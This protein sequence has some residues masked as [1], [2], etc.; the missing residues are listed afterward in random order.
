[1]TLVGAGGPQNGFPMP[2]ELFRVYAPIGEALKE[3]FTRGIEVWLEVDERLPRDPELRSLLRQIALD[4]EGYWKIPPTWTP[5]LVPPVRERLRELDVPTLAIVGE[6]DLAYSLDV[7]LEL[8]RSMPRARRLIV[9]GAGH[10]A[11]LEEPAWFNDLVL[12]EIQALNEP[13]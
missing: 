10:L 4:N 1:L 9:P 13:A 2:S 8:E 3:S 5:P 12:S 6:R 7:A 11:H